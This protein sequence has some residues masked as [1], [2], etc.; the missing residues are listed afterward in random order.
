MSG[1]RKWLVFIVIWLV[2]LGGGAAAYKFLL[3]PPDGGGGG[4]GGGPISAKDGLPVPFILWG[5]D[6]ATFLANGGLETKPGTTF[7]KQG[8]KL[9][10]VR[11]D[12]FEQQV[13]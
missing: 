12:D 2:I 8:L 3:S 1:S 13:K 10:L 11:G 6:V 4:G 7:D 9:K 5:G